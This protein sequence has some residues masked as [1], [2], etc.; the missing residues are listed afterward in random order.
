MNQ[1]DVLLILEAM[2]MEHAVKASM[3]GTVHS[4]L[5]SPDARVQDGQLL[6][7]IHTQAASLAE[8]E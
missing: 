3:N 7:S 1:G 8:E 6:M 4:V 2:K 5:V